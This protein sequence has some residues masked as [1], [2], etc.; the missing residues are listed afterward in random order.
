MNATKLKYLSGLVTITLFLA[1]CAFDI[2]HI[3]YKTANFS[4]CSNNC[5]AFTITKNK[6]LTG[7]PCG[8]N[9][10]IKKDSKWSMVG[11]IDNGDVYKP[12]NQSFSIECSN[13]FEAYLVMSGTM[14]HGFYL[15]VDN[16]YVALDKPIK[17]EKK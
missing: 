7:M 15:P 6:S 12:V 11:S 17:L 8:Y 2:A 16:G 10:T 3:N 13:V 5:P 1:N 9:R 14:L 4:V